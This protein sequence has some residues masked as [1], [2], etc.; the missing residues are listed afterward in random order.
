MK[1]SEILFEWKRSEIIS[2]FCREKYI[3]IEI[4]FK[5]SKGQNDKYTP[6]RLTFDEKLAVHRSNRLNEIFGQINVSNESQSKREKEINDETLVPLR[7]KPPSNT[8]KYN[9][10]FQTNNSFIFL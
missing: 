7:Y 3:I 9:S 10:Y 4:L 8:S 6:S 2:R 5:Y 1:L